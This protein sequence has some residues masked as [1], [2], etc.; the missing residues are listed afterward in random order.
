MLNSPFHI[1]SLQRC[2]LTTLLVSL[3]FFMCSWQSAHAD[4]SG[5][6]EGGSVVRD[7]GTATRLR[8]VLRND[9]RPLNQLVYAE[10]LNGGT[11]DNSYA[12]G[13][14]PRYWLD[15]TFYLFG[16]SSVG[17][18]EPLN[19]DRD[20]QLVVGVGGQFLASSTQGLYAQIG[21]GGRS[22]EFDFDDDAVTQTLGLVR[23]GYYREFLDLFKFDIDVSGSSSSED[24]TEANID[25]GL[26][27]RV[28]SGAVRV[29]YRSRYLKADG[30]ASSQTDD[31]VEI[32]FVYGF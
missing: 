32:S 8:L 28:G 17:V 21:V 24:V 16:E 22:L 15:D 12:I 4:W 25:T 30:D 14:N 26:S 7:S 27:T 3:F 11:D 2:C 5:G 29:G 10:W 18:D 1:L 20:I 9:N 31:D 23:V 19:I 13:Y 6:L